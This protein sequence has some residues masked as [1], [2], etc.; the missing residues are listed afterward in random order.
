MLAATRTVEASMAGGMP[1][2]GEGMM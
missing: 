1:D 2:M